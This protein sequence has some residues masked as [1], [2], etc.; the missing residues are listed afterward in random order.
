M[1]S[2]GADSDRS[3]GLGCGHT[4]SGCRVGK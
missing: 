2:G 4:A 1:E 3:P